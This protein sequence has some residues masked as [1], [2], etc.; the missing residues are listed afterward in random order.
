MKFFITTLLLILIVNPSITKGQ[1]LWGDLPNFN[2]NR[3]LGVSFCIGNKV[4]FGQG[5]SGGTNTVNDFWEYDLSTQTWK[6]INTI[7]GNAL[8]GGTAFS[9][10][11]HGYVG[12]GQTSGS[13]FSKAFYRYDVDSNKWVRIADFPGQARNYAAC[14]VIGNKAYVGC[15]YNGFQTFKD[16]YSLDLEN[17]TW[18]KI[19][20]LPGLS[21]SNAFHFSSGGKGYIL[22]GGNFTQSSGS[23]TLKDFF[24]FDPS[25]NSWVQLADFP[26]ENREYGISFSFDLFG[27]VALGFSETGY[28][29]EVWEFN[30]STQTWA[31]RNSFSG[32]WRRNAGYSSSNNRGF[33]VGGNLGTSF[34]SGFYEYKPLVSSTKD[35]FSFNHSITVYPNPFNNFLNVDGFENGFNHQ[36]EIFDFKG[37][38]VFK[39]IDFEKQIFIDLQ[40]GIY[41]LKI[42]DLSN[43]NTSF[44]KTIIKN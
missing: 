41:L 33:M 34:T 32:A 39:K 38:C 21:R 19:S 1:D 20:D 5:S 40:P 30:S 8:I 43:L 28:S 6:A 23:I 10:K 4:Y 24:Q 26:G 14:F 16:F 29:N 36:I 3:S 7:P 37:N 18:T 22:C 13:S 15:G 17:N 2:G 31:N 11:N 42:S 12:L 9:Y 27:I 35:V 44:I 25:L